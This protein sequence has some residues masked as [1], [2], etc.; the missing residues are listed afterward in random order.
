MLRANGDVFVAVSLAGC[1]LVRNWTMAV[2]VIYLLLLIVFSKFGVV[3]ESF[4]RYG[5]SF[6]WS[7]LG[8]Y[9]NVKIACVIILLLLSIYHSDGTSGIETPL[10]SLLAA[11]VI[12][13][14]VDSFRWS[15]LVRGVAV[16]AIAA[17]VLGLLQV[18]VYA[19]DR[20]AGATNLVRYG[21]IAMAL[22]SIC[23]VDVVKARRDWISSGLSLIGFL[24]GVGGAL[25]SGS[26]GALLALPFILALLAPV[27][28]RRSRGLFMMLSL[29][30]V[31]FVGALLFANVGNMA[32]RIGSAYSNLSASVTGGGDLDDGSV[33][34]RTRLLLLAIKLFRQAPLSGVG[35]DGW[36]KEIDI[37]SSAPEWL[38]RMKPYNQ[39]HNQYAD[40]LAK[41]G[42]IRFLAGFLQLFLPLYFFLKYEPYSGKSETRFALAGLVVS[43][44][45]MVFCLTESLM[46][47]SL[48][49]VVHSTMIF[50][51]LAACFNAGA[52]KEEAPPPTAAHR[53]PG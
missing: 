21:M 6:V 12:V 25:L 42:M 30:F 9:Y 48:S 18:G 27:L 3:F 34:D 50:S 23:A 5:T 47:L 17:L 29:G 22:G 49:S 35:S 51:L 24:A 8:I 36:N 2:L 7:R 20:T 11:Y 38:D 4:K 39:A 15:V 43:M 40:D 26:R 19:A 52:N 46:I 44:A 10:K 31:L 33:G 32:T 1:L 45:F 13:M 53:L 16:G 41:G 37:L 14:C 28:W